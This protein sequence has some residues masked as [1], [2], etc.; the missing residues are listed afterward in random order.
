MKKRDCDLDT[1]LDNVS[2]FYAIFFMTFV[3][4]NVIK[5]Q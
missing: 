2:L 1:T 3:E 4:I 5:Y